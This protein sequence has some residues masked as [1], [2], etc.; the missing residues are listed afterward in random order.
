MRDF[1]VQ[2][3]RHEDGFINGEF[4]PEI[5]GWHCMFYEYNQTNI[6]DW[7]ETNMKGEYDCIYRFN[8]G[9][10]AYFITIKE[11]EDATLFKLTWV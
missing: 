8:S 1:V 7:M 9:D 3:W 6:E 5:K 11:S 10:P 4:R 2:H